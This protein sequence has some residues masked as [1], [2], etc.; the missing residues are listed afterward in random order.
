MYF[1]NNI[2]QLIIGFQWKPCTFKINQLFEGCYQRSLQPSNLL[3]R[4]NQFPLLIVN[5][6]ARNLNTPADVKNIIKE[7]RILQATT[8]AELNGGIREVSMFFPK[9][10]AEVKG[11]TGEFIVLVLNQPTDIKR[12]IASTELN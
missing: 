9:S 12:C 5:H 1:C 4:L 3:N 10:P 8:P 11:H 6:E 7:I 2:K